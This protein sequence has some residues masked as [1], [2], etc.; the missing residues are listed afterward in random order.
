MS[1]DISKEEFLNYKLENIS[2]VYYGKRDCCRCGCG[3][4]YISTSFAMDDRSDM[5]DK[6]ALKRLKRAQKLI[7]QGADFNSGD[8]YFDVKT[9]NDLTLTFYNEVVKNK[10]G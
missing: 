3:G 10:L 4:E 8:N 9:G 1:K 7:E 2:Q 6:L 5:N